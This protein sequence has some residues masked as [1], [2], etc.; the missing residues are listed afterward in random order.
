L[1]ES[2]VALMLTTGLLLLMGG[3]VAQHHRV[4]RQLGTRI[5]GVESARM[6]RDLISVAVAVD[7]GAFVEGGELRVRSFVG[8]AERCG[9]VGWD[10]RGRR[11]PDAAKD[12][13][14]V[15]TAEGRVQLAEVVGHDS[16]ECA[17]P[18]EGRLLEL[19]AEPPLPIDARLVRVFEP[20][21]FR[22]DDALRYGRAGSGAQPLSAPVLDP[23]RSGIASGAEGVSVILFPEGR[24]EGYSG[25]WGR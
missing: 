11:L 1:V 3:I 23:I 25:E 19:R 13:L 24:I 14:W 21:R 5:E 10:Y 18:E 20:G 16:G 22:L 9:E 12:S 7:S 8:V 15:V 6:T 17:R 2:L 4:A